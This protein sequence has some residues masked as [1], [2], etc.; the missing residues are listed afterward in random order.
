MFK[1]RSQVTTVATPNIIVFGVLMQ[2]LEIPKS[3]SVTLGLGAVLKPRQGKPLTI[4]GV[5][6]RLDGRTLSFTISTKEISR[7]N[8]LEGR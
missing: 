4:F 1:L 5:I 3:K 2:G 7:I 6:L 8:L